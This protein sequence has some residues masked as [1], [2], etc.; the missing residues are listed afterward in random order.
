[1]IMQNQNSIVKFMLENNY[2]FNIINTLS[3]SMLLKTHEFGKAVL[4]REGFAMGKHMISRC[5]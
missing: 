2:V 3:H 1:M 4:G 5:N